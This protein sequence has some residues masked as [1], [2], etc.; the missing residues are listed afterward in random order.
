MVNKCK[1]LEG[2]L[3]NSDSNSILSFDNR[4]T[5][6]FFILIITDHNDDF[7]LDSASTPIHCYKSGEINLL[8]RRCI[9]RVYV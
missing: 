3:I 5:G 8:F 9:T 7:V 6:I 1:S 4:K 2:I